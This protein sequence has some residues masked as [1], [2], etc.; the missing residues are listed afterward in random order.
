MTKILSF[1]FLLLAVS[2]VSSFEDNIENGNYNKKSRK[3][4]IEMS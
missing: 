3:W 4:N 2:Y 1:V